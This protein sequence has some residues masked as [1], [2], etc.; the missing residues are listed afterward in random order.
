MSR[1]IPQVKRWKV[2]FYYPLTTAT[3][4][5]DA[6]TR[7][8][9]IWAAREQRHGCTLYDHDCIRESASVLRNVDRR[10]EFIA[11]HGVTGGTLESRST[12]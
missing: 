2:T 9:A 12:K 10:R 3:E 1:N 4:Y 8:F 6:P 11:R 5:V 7:L